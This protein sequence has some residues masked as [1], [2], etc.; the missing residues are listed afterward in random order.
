MYNATMSVLNEFPG[1]SPFGRVIDSYF[2]EVAPSVAVRNRSVSNVSIITG[3]EYLRTNSNHQALTIRDLLGN[4]LDEGTMFVPT[5]LNTTAELIDFLKSK[6]YLELS[7][8][9]VSF[10]ESVSL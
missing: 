1:F 10:T 5:T 3:E 7:I 4:D 2:H 8:Y 9:C 6:Y